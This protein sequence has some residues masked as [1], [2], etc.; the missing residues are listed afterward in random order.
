MG[1]WEG[2]KQDLQG[3]L[4]GNNKRMAFGGKGLLE[5]GLKFS[6]RSGSRDWGR[7]SHTCSGNGMGDEGKALVSMQIM[8]SRRGSQCW[9]AARERGARGWNW[10]YQEWK[11]G[12]AVLMV[13]AGEAGTNSSSVRDGILHASVLPFCGCRQVSLTSLGLI[14]TD[15][16]FVQKIAT[17]CHCQLCQSIIKSVKGAK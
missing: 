8:S 7:R 6:L 2:G 10:G 13:G 15:A 11:T 5:T 9:K 3:K 14:I 16:G 17:C 4:T 12:Q 1:I